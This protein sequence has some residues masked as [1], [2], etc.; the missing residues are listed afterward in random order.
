MVEYIVAIDVTRVRFPANKKSTTQT[1]KPI[2]RMQPGVTGRA[3]AVHRL[4]PARRL[5]ECLEDG[6]ND[7]GAMV[8]LDPDELC[9]PR[10]EELPYLRE[11][12]V[13]DEVPLQECW[14]NSNRAH[15]PPSGW[16]P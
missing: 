11:V 13:Y 2:S 1:A 6:M 16:T 5:G 7:E 9:K 14:D 4:W 10:E 3:E 12:K 15:A 8:E